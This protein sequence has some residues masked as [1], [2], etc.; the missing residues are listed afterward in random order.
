MTSRLRQRPTWQNLLARIGSL[1][2][3]RLPTGLAGIPESVSRSEDD[4]ITF[5]TASLGC[6]DG[7]TE[8]LLAED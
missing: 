8:R 1:L 7:L 2:S 6:L 4:E 5:E 3:V